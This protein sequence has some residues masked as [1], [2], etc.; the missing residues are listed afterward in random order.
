M[1]LVHTSPNTALINHLRSVLET[2]GIECRVRGEFLAVAVGELPPIECWAELWVVDDDRHDEAAELVRR[3]SDRDPAAL[4]EWV[5]PD[6]AE[7][8]DAELTD[9]WNCGHARDLLRQ[10]G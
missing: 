4:G 3:E 2:L 5:C 8:V 7:T 10:A 6:C 9:C 1:C